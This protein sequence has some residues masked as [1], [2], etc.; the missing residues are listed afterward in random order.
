MLKATTFN[1]YTQ[2]PNSAHIMWVKPTAFGGQVGLPVSGDQESQYTSTSILYRQFEP[3]ILNGIIYY[4]LYPNVPTTVTSAGGTPG[5][6]AVDLRTG[7]LLWHK[8]TNDTLVFGMVHAIPHYTGI[9]NPSIPSCNRSK[10]RYR[11]NSLQRLA[12]L[13]PNDWILH[14]QHY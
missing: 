5:W 7:E 11:F 2:A 8:D 3:I 1:P 4:K 14:C 9:R 6:N 12:T 10:R 13:R